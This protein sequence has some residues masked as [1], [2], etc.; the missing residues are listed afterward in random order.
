ME[1]GGYVFLSRLYTVASVCAEGRWKVRR[2]ELESVLQLS[3]VLFSVR[4]S[5]L[6]A[7]R[8]ERGRC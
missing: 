1:D 8:T 5:L 3:G 2:L 6:E 7:A 4:A